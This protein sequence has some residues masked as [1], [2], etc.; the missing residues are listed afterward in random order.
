MNHTEPD[1][2][3]KFMALGYKFRD[4]RQPRRLFLE[5]AG[6]THG[7]TVLDYGCGTGSYVVPSAQMVGSEGKVYAL[8]I[9]S[10]A[11]R[12][13]TARIEKAH[14]A[15]VTTIL[16]GCDTGLSNDCVDVALLYDIFHDLSD[17]TAVLSELRRVLKP[18]GI[19]SS[20]DHHLKG[21]MLTEAIESTELFQLTRKSPLTCSFTP[22]KN[23]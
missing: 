2:S 12:M 10:T 19:L 18:G 11:L 22:R 5:E 9:N 8:D 13:V 16:S 4:M 6:V 3:F 14:M 15:N 17:P 20:H 7:L 21:D 1:W 23:W